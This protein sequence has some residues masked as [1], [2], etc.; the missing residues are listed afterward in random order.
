MNESLT[1]RSEESGLQISVIP[2]NQTDSFYNIQAEYPQFEE[3]NA[4]FNKEISDLILGE[5]KSFKKQAKDNW[6]ARNATL[7]PGE[8]PLANPPS[9]FD[10]IASWT[11]TQMNKKY[12]S[13]SVNIYYFAGGAHGI[14][15][16]DTF[17]YDVAKEADI[18]INDFLDDSPQALQ[19]LSQI[20]AQRVTSQLQSNSV[21]IND[22]LTQM[23][24]Q[25]TQPTTDNYRNFNFNYNSLTVYFQ[26]YQVAPG[27]LGPVTVVLYKNTL[28]DNSIRS[29]Y[30]D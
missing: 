25:G 16:I 22:V 19:K 2:I 30:L 7:L 4:V 23:I 27:Y 26:Q 14:T 6:D 21:E 17:N 3:V 28:E 10:F 5:I 15:E 9:P 24:Q 18:T 29:Y 8:T 1:E 13:F 20:A 11:P 12:I